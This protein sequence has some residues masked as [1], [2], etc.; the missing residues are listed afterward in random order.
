MSD[1]EQRLAAIEARNT[2]VE[3][4]KTWETS[5]Q[6]RTAIC[7][8]TYVFATL[9]LYTIGGPTPWVHA[10]VPVLGYLLSTFSLRWMRNRFEGK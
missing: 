1:I 4:D 2:R 3:T 7:A 9:W 6:R 10:T 8:L 5:W